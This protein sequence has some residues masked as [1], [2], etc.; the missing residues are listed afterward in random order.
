M[1]QARNTSKKRSIGAVGAGDGMLDPRP[2]GDLL[3]ELGHLRSQD[4][5]SAFH[6]TLDGGLERR[7]QAAALSLKIDEGDRISH[8]KLRCNSVRL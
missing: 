4:P 8:A 6:R 7:T 5:L 1:S 3:F 2:G